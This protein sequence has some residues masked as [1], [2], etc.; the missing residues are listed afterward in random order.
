MKQNALKLDDRAPLRASS[1]NGWNSALVVPD[2]DLVR[3][4]LSVSCFAT[5]SWSD[6]FTS[7]PPCFEA[8]S[9]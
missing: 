5:Y 6:A 9:P 7:S 1:T 8:S 3:P 2:D 4:D